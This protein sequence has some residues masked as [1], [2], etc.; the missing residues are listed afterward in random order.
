[1]KK[2]HASSLIIPRRSIAVLG[3]VLIALV[4]LYTYFVMF[5]IFHVVARE[6]A[7]RQS[8]VLADKVAMLEQQYLEKSQRLTEGYARSLG[9]VSSSSRSFIERT[10]V[11]VSVASGN[12]R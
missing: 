9:F 8:E 3:C 1:M 6:D 11:A 4:I 2:K 10:T 7:L 5:S 12:A